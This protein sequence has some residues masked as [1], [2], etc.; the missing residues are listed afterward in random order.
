[1]K[2]WQWYLVDLLVWVI[3]SCGCVQIQDKFWAVTVAMVLVTISK[4]ILNAIKPK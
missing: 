3:I 1:M 2:L 4:D